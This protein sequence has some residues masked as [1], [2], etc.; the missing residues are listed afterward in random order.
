MQDV[1]LNV[2][3]LM[4]LLSQSGPEE[5][6]TAEASQPVGDAA[7][8]LFPEELLL[9]LNSKW[10][11]MAQK[12]DVVQVNDSDVEEEE[13]DEEEDSESDDDTSDI[14]FCRRSRLL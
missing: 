1:T 3:S 12:S 11:L 13:E 6:N 9:Q 14:N 5:T 4:N 7:P 8:M 2:D 10:N